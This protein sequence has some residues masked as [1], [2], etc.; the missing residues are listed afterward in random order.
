LTDCPARGR[1]PAFATSLARL[2]T[3]KSAVAENA[4][5]NFEAVADFMDIS[6][7]A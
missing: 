6:R 1:P 4:S 2:A 5:I 3:E 7:K